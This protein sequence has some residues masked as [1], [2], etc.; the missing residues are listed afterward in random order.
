MTRTDA[1]IL[2]RARELAHSIP[3]DLAVIEVITPA[4]EDLSDA[5]IQLL[6]LLS[7][8]ETG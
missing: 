1:E 5:V 6:C 8:D 7:E 3:E 2:A 4:G